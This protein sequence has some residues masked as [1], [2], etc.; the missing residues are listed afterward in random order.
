VRVEHS[1][2][3][4]LA[5]R[6]AGRD[7]S[8]LERQL[9]E[10]TV[11]VGADGSLPGSDLAARVLLPTLRRLPGRLV[12]DRGNL[13]AHVVDRLV[14]AVVAIDPERGLEVVDGLAGRAGV[15]LHVGVDAPE[16]AIGIVADR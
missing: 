12:L 1:R 5:E 11:L 4:R 2:A 8:E 3:L 10:G 6:A 7:A 15:R 14:E 9:E 13:P 16:G